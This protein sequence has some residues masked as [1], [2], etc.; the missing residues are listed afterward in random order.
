MKTPRTLNLHITKLCNLRCSY[1]SHFSSDGASGEDLPTE[2][3]LKF[4]EELNQCA[5]LDVCLCGGEPLYRKDFRKL[6]DGIVKNKMCFSI[7]SNGILLDDEIIEYLKNT[8]RCSYFQL[9]ID[10]PGPESH[11]IFRGKGAFE[12]AISGL[13]CL[14][15]HGI[16]TTVRVTIHKHNVKTLDEVAELLLED[17]GL[18]S[19][20]TNSAGHLGL[21]RKNKVDIQL[22]TDEYSEAMVK[23]VKLDEKYKGRIGAQAGPLASAK[24]WRGMEIARQQGQKRLTGRGFLRSCGGVFNKIAILADGTMVP[25]GELSHLRL[26]QINKDS[27]RD[28]WINHPELKR[29]RERND[30]SLESF[31]YCKGCEYVSY[32]IGG[33]PALAYTITGDENKPAPDTCYRA[34]L[35]AG[36]QLP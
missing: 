30:I 22:T 3:W 25:C 12:K 36:G 13:K 1:C 6:V 21:C 31:D 32:C 2:E 14:M 15:K 10:G 34:F 4:F 33:C 16:P 7:L 11:D 26:G 19:F 23:L 28:V 27:L 20:S 8:G 18:T 29:L 24:G 35:R 17:I 5:V 9:S